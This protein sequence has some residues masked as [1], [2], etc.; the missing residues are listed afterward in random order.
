MIRMESVEWY[1]SSELWKRASASEETHREW[2]FTVSVPASEVFDTPL[3]ETVLMQG[4]IDF[5]F[6]EDGKWVLVDYKTD[7][8]LPDETPQSHAE[9]HRRQLELYSVA[10]QRITGKPVSEKYV[11]MLNSR[12]AVPLL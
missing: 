1:V 10:L 7:A 12:A 4:V 9:V 8:L 3:S 6:L 2:N 11:V 5:C